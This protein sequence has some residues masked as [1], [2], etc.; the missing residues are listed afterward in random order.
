MPNVKRMS[1]SMNE[2]SIRKE[3][4]RRRGEK[5]APQKMIT[6]TLTNHPLFSL[7]VEGYFMIGLDLNL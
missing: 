5:V 2:G 7:T 1:E 4:G 3:Y 6:K